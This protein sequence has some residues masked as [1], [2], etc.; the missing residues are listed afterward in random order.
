MKERL[1]IITYDM[2]PYSNSWGSCQRM[3]YLAKE[4]KNQNFDIS[5]IAALKSKFGF[6]GKKINFDIEYLPKKNI[7]NKKTEKKR[8]KELII[9]FLKKIGKRIDKFYFNDPF[10]GMG[11]LG[12]FW[13]KKSKKDILNFI[14]EKQIKK[15]II[16]GPPFSLFSLIHDIK[17]IEKD[18]KIVLDLRDPWNTW[19]DNIGIPCLREKKILNIADQVIVA[20][21]NARKEKINKFKL[22][23]EKVATVYNG[24][25]REEWLKVEKKYVTK[26]KNKK[27]IISY[28][29]N[30]DFK[31]GGFRDTK[32]FFEAYEQ[33]KK[34]QKNIIIRF[35]GVEETK[36]IRDLKKKYPEIEFIKKISSDK[37]MEEMLKSD[38][39][40]NIHTLNDKSSELLI[41]GKIFDYIRSNKVIFSITPNNSIV[42]KLIKAEKFGIASENVVEDLY[43]A[44]KLIIERFSQ[45]KLGELRDDNV[46][47]INEYSREF[48]NKNFIEIINN[49]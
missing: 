32:Y 45:E 28:L 18:I 10:P 40:L 6:F 11:L 1:L 49:I 39:L 22:P 23:K 33:L 31:P 25:C 5:M 9:K 4:L 47:K 27:C 21:E 44:L 37:A 48:Q 43:N 42:S 24:Y 15:I 41:A 29:G 3:Y 30:I 34:E 35:I 14:K 13:I 16:S 12:Y 38:V 46:Q 36:E 17:K 19:N 26:E 20:T 2:I 8:K 7:I